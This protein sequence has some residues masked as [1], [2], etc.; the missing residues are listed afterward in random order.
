MLAVSTIALLLVP[1][2]AAATGPRALA[3]VV[4]PANPTA[5]L[6]FTELRTV[7]LGERTHWG[8]GRRITLVMRDSRQP[9]REAVLQLVYR[10]D[11]RTLTRHFLQA[12]FTGAIHEPKRLSSGEGVRRFVFNVPGAIGYLWADELDASVKVVKVDGRGPGE[13]GYRLVAPPP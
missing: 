12:V 4:N 5:D 13:P 10:M 6:S 7:F 9:E 8:H 1:A 11:D 3:I 2:P